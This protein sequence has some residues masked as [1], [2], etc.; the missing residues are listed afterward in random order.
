MISLSPADTWEISLKMDTANAFFVGNQMF[1]LGFQRD[2]EFTVGSRMIMKI[3]T[4]PLVIKGPDA[5]AEDLLNRKE[6]GQSLLNLVSQSSDELVISLD[7]KWG[8]GKNTFV[9]MWQ[10]M[11]SES[12]VPSIYIDAYKNDYLDD[13]FM[14]I[15]SAILC[16]IEDNIDEESEE[17]SEELK[18]K[19][20]ELAVKVVYW[21][22]KLAVRTVTSGLVNGSD[23]DELTTNS[24]EGDSGYLENI[25]EDRLKNRSKDVALIEEF[26]ALLSGIPSKLREQNDGPLVVII[27]EL[28]R[29]RPSFAVEFIEKIKH[30]FSVKN[31]VFL[32]VMNK[33]QLE[34]SVRFV[35]GSN[36]D[37]RAY[38]QKFIN[39]ETKIP[40]RESGRIDGDLGKYAR[41][42]LRLHELETFDQDETLV[43][44][45]VPWAEY[46]KLSLRQ[47]E[48]I[49]TNLALFYGS[50]NKNDYISVPLVVF[51]A[52]TKVVSPNTFERLM[53]QE[54]SYSE[55]SDKFE[56]SFD[57]KESTE[58]HHLANWV[59]YGLLSQDEFSALESDDPIRKFWDTHCEYVFER[60]NLIPLF[61]RK[62]NV[63]VVK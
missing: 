61:A 23:I 6:Y 1:R 9:K 28:D 49:Y 34:E 55:V 43:R 21:S 7:G 50:S 8:E 12:D 3:V 62:M 32:L 60:E 31:V 42:L 58:L 16:F 22:A 10:C 29:C 4:P 52:T 53:K 19:A 17:K 35:Y 5:F 38:L 56:F 25:I 20:K 63:F 26:R 59:R 39:V 2:G 51:L 36:I 45:L 24:S 48:R 46:F 37:A 33:D 18:K 14:C 54:I 47:L 40:K 15:A 57:K 41:K 11:L 27:D 13:V 44:C 30:F